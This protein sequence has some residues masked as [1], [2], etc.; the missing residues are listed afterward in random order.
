MS[1][2]YGHESR[3]YA[4]SK[5][6]F[7]QSWGP[8]LRASGQASQGEL[9]ATGYSCRS[10]AARLQDQRLRHPVEVLL[11]CMMPARQTTTTTTG[12]T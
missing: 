12:D 6:I 11:E 10:Q 3:N 8:L 7:G 9:L 2:T 1:G 4:T 5:I